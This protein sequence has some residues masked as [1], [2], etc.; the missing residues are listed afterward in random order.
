MHVYLCYINEILTL[1]KV[2]V[3]PCQ[4]CTDECLEGSIVYHFS[5][6]ALL[7]NTHMY[8]Y[9]CIL[10]Y[11]IILLNIGPSMLYPNVVFV[12]VAF[13]QD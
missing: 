12:Q 10:V 4:T 9:A 5:Y 11:A 3:S 7:I 2:L 13:S 8:I 6:I 1:L